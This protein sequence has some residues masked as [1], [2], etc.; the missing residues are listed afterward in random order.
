VDAVMAIIRRELEI[1]K[2]A[3]QTVRES[4]RAAITGGQ[5]NVG[6]PDMNVIDA[7]IARR[8]GTR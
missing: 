8:R 5:P 7:E 2:K 6:M 3:P 1:A 4:T